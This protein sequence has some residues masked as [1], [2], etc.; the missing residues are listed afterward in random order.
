M[1]GGQRH[2]IRRL[3]DRASPA[4]CHRRLLIGV[5]GTRETRCVADDGKTRGWLDRIVGGSHAVVLL[6]SAV[7]M[8]L[9][10]DTCPASSLVLPPTDSIATIARAPTACA[11]SLRPGFGRRGRLPPNRGY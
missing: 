11:A 9:C 6:A 5:P 2:G 4:F 10:G 1:Q 8:W 3:S 7:R